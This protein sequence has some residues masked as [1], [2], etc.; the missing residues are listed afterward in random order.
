MSGKAKR[1]L[2]AIFVLLFLV[3]VTGLVK[4]GESGQPIDP[5]FRPGT[6]LEVPQEFRTSKENNPSGSALPSSTGVWSTRAADHARGLG[7]GLLVGAAVAVGI[8]AVGALLAVS[9][10]VLAA[11]AVGALVGGALY[12]LFTGAARFNPVDAAVQAVIGGVSAG[13]GFGLGA[14]GVLAGRGL[15][16]ARA[17]I[18]VVAGGLG[19]LASYLIQAPDPSP[20]GAAMAFGL[21]AGTAGLFLGAGYGFARLKLAWSATRGANRLVDIG[22]DFA[23]PSWEPAG[24]VG[25]PVVAS[26]PAAIQRATQ[27][28][29]FESPELTAYLH[30]SKATRVDTVEALA[31]NLENA[32]ASVRAV[33]SEIIANGSR[34]DRQQAITAYGEGVGDW[35]RRNPIQADVTAQSGGLKGLVETARNAPKVDS[36]KLAQN[37]FEEF[38]LPRSRGWAAHHIVAGN[39][40]EAEPARMI[41][42][43]FGIDINDAY[44]GVYLPQ[45]PSVGTTEMYHRSLHTQVYHESVYLRLWD[46]VDADHARAILQEIASELR[47]GIF[48][49]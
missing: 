41:L 27:S 34:A 6:T 4:A 39:E 18:D 9:A 23:L 29:P 3:V 10:P 49:K 40:P 17:A 48:P 31:K 30:G 33:F 14:A 47:A 45:E 15:L 32:P 35:I 26:N 21:G 11:A 20:G 24:E 22:T 8:V 13:V 12:G 16:A 5:A 38:R 37:M 19:S 42:Q 46:G 7:M 25:I 44:N 43:R 2:M 1:R 36:E 28:G